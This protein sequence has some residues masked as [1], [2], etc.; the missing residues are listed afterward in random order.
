MRMKAL[1]R[2]VVT[3]VRLQWFCFRRLTPFLLYGGNLEHSFCRR[4]KC[5]CLY[6][7][8]APVGQFHL[9]LCIAVSAVVADAANCLPPLA[10]RI[11]HLSR[12]PSPDR[13]DTIVA[14]Q[15]R[16]LSLQHNRCCSETLSHD[17]DDEGDDNG[18][19]VF[20]VT[21]RW[22]LSLGCG[23]A[24]RSTRM[25]AANVSR[26]LRN[27]PIGYYGYHLSGSYFVAVG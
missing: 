12:V 19:D 4:R 5:Y 27:R 23:F 15:C 10:L 17:D 21:R 1:L 25:S 20:V 3:G 14:A 24:A 22:L 2:C 13:K 8:R 6:F 26:L 11:P 16:N 9:R 18:I 7:L